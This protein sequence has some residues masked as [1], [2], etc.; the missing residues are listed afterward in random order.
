M[1]AR[2]LL[3]QADEQM[4]EAL[5]RQLIVVVM[6]WLLG[7]CG[8]PDPANMVAAMNDSNIRKVANLYM[9]YQ[10][11]HGMVGPKDEVEFKQFI[12]TE[13]QPNKLE[14]M[15]I[16]PSNVDALFVS[17][18]TSQPFEVIYGLRGST[19]AVAAVV[20]DQP[21][22]S[23]KRRVGFTNSP[24]REVDEQQYEQLKQNPQTKIETVPTAQGK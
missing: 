19:M 10:I 8:G 15:N 17:E 18:T 21:G 5:R 4:R 6:P 13:M 20:F 23:G 3:L 1:I 2:I 22:N 24:V 12:Q 7:G 9:A 11:R 16:D 14:M